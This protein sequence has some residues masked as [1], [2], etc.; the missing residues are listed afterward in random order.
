M[1]QHWPQLV[2]WLGRNARAHNVG[3]DDAL[4]PPIPTLTA[5]NMGCHCS[6]FRVREIKAHG[7]WT[8]I[9]MISM[10]ESSKLG[11]KNWFW[12]AAMAMS[13]FTA[14]CSQT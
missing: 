14:Y 3:V 6:Y 9:T 12:V 11:S 4:S 5:C 2:D 10:A 7:I 13:F 8:S 1:P